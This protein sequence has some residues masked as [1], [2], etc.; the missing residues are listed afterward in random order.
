MKSDHVRQIIGCRIDTPTLPVD[1]VDFVL[2]QS[3][4]IKTIPEMGVTVD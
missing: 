2:I 1:D 4:R 3:T